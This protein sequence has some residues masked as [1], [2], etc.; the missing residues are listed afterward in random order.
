MVEYKRKCFQGSSPYYTL[1]L[2]RNFKTWG[3]IQD[4]QKK[5]KGAERKFYCEARCGSRWTF[6]C[7]V[8]AFTCHLIADTHWRPLSYGDKGRGS[9][10]KYCN[11]LTIIRQVI[12][13]WFWD[14]HFSFKDHGR[15]RNLKK[16]K[17]SD[18]SPA[19]WY[20]KYMY[21]YIH[22]CIYICIYEW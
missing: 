7:L 13:K 1:Q 11:I 21:T 12:F 4:N 10:N 22:T 19:K 16:K 14:V 8:V 20:Q 3:S 2:V 15:G 18:V 5:R 9:S 17:G 6:T